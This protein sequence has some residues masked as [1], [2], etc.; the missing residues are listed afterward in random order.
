LA[1]DVNDATLQMPLRIFLAENHIVMRGGLRVLLQARAA[2]HICGEADNGHEAIELVLRTKPNIVVMNINLPGIN[3]IEV[4]RQIH[5]ALPKT[6]I[7]I[8][9]A[10]NDEHF[11]RAAM[12]AGA[13]GYVLKSAS[14]EQVIDAIQALARH[15]RYVSGAVSE[16]LLNNLAH[17]E[18]SNGDGEHL[19][20][21]EGDVLRLIARGYRSRE[22]ALMLGI[23]I[24]T[25]DTHRAAA[26][27]KLQLRSVAQVVRYAIRQKLIEA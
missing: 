2:F 11:V 9:T 3:G 27:G 15:Q 8:F 14:D 10:E 25:V 5:N 21:R 23:S 12:N 4:T 7:L 22:I 24:K 19:T 16:K 1:P 18:K 13:R 26:M 20:T 17:Q 6:E